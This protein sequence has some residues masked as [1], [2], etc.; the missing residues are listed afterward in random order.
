[1]PPPLGEYRLQDWLHL[2]PLGHRV[3][4][5]RYRRVDARFV[6]QP[7]RVGD[8]AALRAA[9]R[10]RRVLFTV[11]FNDVQA[12]DWQ[13]SLV[14][15][16]VADCVYVVAD[17][18]P[19]DAVAAEIEARAKARGVLYLRLP[20]N[21]WYSAA[22]KHASRS[23]GICLNW[24]WRNI[25]LPGEPESFGFLDHDIFPTAPDDP[26]APLAAQDF[27]GVVRVWDARW[28]LWAGFC[29][30]RFAAV[31]NLPLDFGQDWFIG[32]DTGGGN[33][34]PLYRH[35][36][37]A[38]LAERDSH[39]APFRPDVTIEDAPFQWCGPWLH[40]VG[41]TGRPEFAPLKRARLAEILAPLL[42]EPAPASSRL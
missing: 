5:A 39:L 18:T 1:M 28:F 17:N 41:M 36:D 20:D 21:P 3:K 42:D 10:S 32:L 30:Y 16:F 15:R 37:R 23:H 29:F 14:P 33:W 2:R 26:F 27:Y 7:A 24:L 38:A 34:E 8:D 11:A 4:T 25:I 35:A 9:I 12:I 13:M 22:K 6:A 40:E 19:D 31:R